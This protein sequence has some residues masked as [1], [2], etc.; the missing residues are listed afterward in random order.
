MLVAVL[1][2]VAGTLLT[3]RVC[4]GLALKGVLDRIQSRRNKGDSLETR[5]PKDG[6]F[7]IDQL[8]AGRE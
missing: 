7:A 4:A 5:S 1:V 8:I 3:T 2:P 6:R